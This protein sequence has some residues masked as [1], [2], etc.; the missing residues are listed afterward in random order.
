MKVCPNCREENSDRAKFCQVCATPLEE[1]GPIERRERKVITVVFCDLVGFTAASDKADPEDVQGRLSPYHARLRAEMERFGGTVEKF[2][3]DAVMAVFGAP[4][5]HEDD[6][7]RAVRGALR[8]L[9]AIDEL[10]EGDPELGL[11]VRIG[12]NTGEAVA[13]LG[14]RPD[15]GEGI[16]TGDV[17]NTAARLQQAAPVG[18]VVVGVTTYRTTRDAIEYEYL[19]PVTVKGKAEPIAIWRAVG[20][21]SGLA[22]GGELR[23]TT[24]FIGRFGDLAL[25]RQT[26]ARVVREAS[27]Q[28]VT[29]TGEPGVG[30]SRL[31]SEFR[32]SLDAEA[33]PVAWRQ[34]RCL[35]YGE[36][37]TFWALGE[38]VKEEAG[39][40]ESDSPEQA[41]EKLEAAVPPTIEDPSDRD[42]MGTR[43]APLVGAPTPEAAG[44]VERAEYFTAWRRF[45][46]ALASDRPL[47]L[48]FDD[49]HW[50]DDPM[51]DFVEYLADWSAGVPLLVIAVARPELYDQ[52]P[53]WAGGKRN[54][55]SIALG[56]L[57]QEE[58]AKLITALLA[59]AILPAETQAVLLERAGG[60]PLY[61]EEFARMLTDSGIIRRRGK[62]MALAPGVE[63]PVPETVLALIAARLD[64]LSPD[65]KALLFDAAVVGKVFW[66]G[67][68]S[69]MGGVDP[70]TVDE[71]LHELARKELVRPSRTSSVKDQAEYS[72]WHVL[73]RDVA[74]GM[75]PRADRAAKHRAAAGWIERMSGERVADA[76]ELL[77]HHYVQALELARASRSGPTK[78]L[79]VTARRFLV[80]A[81][82]R[83]MRLDV[84][85]AKSYYRQALELL[86]PGDAER[87][88]V[89]TKAAESS[90]LSSDFGEAEREYEEAIAELRAQG[91]AP[92]AADAMVSL[93]LLHGFRGRTALARTLMEELIEMLEREP[94]G[95]QLAR[96]YG[97]IARD[98]WLSGH[99]EEANEW[100]SKALALAEELGI[101]EVAV[102][103]RQVRGGS[104]CQL[105]DMGGLD[106]LRSAL[107]LSLEY[108]LG[109]ETVRGHINLG[110]WIWWIEGPA[111]GLEYLRAGI[112]FGERRGITGA[113][114]WTKGVVLWLQFELGE[115]D[116]LLGSA[117]ELI[118]WDRQ[119][120]GSYFGVWALTARAHVL[121][122]RGRFN[123]AKELE[124]QYLS[125]AREIGDPQI[126]NPALATAAGANAAAGDRALA[127]S[128]VEE[129]DR[130]TRD[131]PDF[132]TLYGHWVARACAA[133]DAIQPLRGLL[134]ANAPIATYHRC[135][136]LTTEAMLAEAE[137]RLQPALD[138]YFQ[139]AQEWE[140]YGDVPEYGHANLGAGR[141]LL[142]LGRIM[143]AET[144][145]KDAR[146][147]FAT[148]GARPLVAQADTLLQRATAQ[149]S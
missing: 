67:A 107:E 146:D 147:V 145:L 38:I 117:D 89:V 118:A 56:P 90:F 91:N 63:I 6:A 74:Y 22:G 17:V 34:G 79:E 97:Q 109:I 121:A 83:A 111:R 62:I 32:T 33:E 87:A 58:T 110:E 76:A 134:E 29:L 72:F 143:E 55:A 133:M 4:V 120:G 51:L 99:A 46:E 50:A 20:A 93:S 119:H 135:S 77:A 52:R 2:I 103:A 11:Q 53:G 8:I 140:S 81:G 7:E 127:V 40:L 148:L 102:M 43:L 95:P 57:T 132:R 82:D 96:A 144:R 66:A 44:T 85:R 106:D 75:I 5:A 45:L 129:F 115:W 112:E 126:L 137:G 47:V 18:A 3:G 123:E 61:A 131:R 16:V 65:R 60:N 138:L 27:V 113:V 42:W 116:Q 101:R 14:A 86:E 104:R 9:D 100:A 78:D 25:L 88:V 73:V 49:L 92:A 39:I 48:V 26:Y 139:A 31:L 70:A 36:G 80:M 21:G 98:K 149:T 71:G 41:G 37:I 28:L 35:P 15:Q 130:L 13:A 124:D 64:T 105:G 59:E 30:K 114:W 141:C 122:L 19:V 108:G 94:P 23:A 136:I 10:N 68:V 54:S 125:R 69:S 128:L 1:I 12:I 84:G 142:G 24:P